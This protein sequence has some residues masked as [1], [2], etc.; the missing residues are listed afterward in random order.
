MKLKEV[1][2]KTIHFFK[3]KKIESPRL[4]A[5]LLLSHGLH[6]T[7]MDIYLKY[8]QPLSEAEVS[9]LRSLV[10]RRVEG[11]PVAYIL[12]RKDFFSTQWK[13]SPAV[14][15]PRPDTEILVEEA[16]DWSKKNVKDAFSILDLGTG[17]GCIGLSLLKNIS[18]SHL[19]TVDISV[20]ALK[21]A[22]ENAENLALLERVDFLNLDACDSLGP[23]QIEQIIGENKIDILVAN[24][25]YIRAN[26]PQL[27]PHVKKYEPHGAL[28]AEDDGL[29]FLK[30]W[31]KNYSVLLNR[32]SVVLMELDPE[33]ANSMKQH[34]E[35]LHIF[36]KIKILKDLSGLD[37][38]IAG[39]TDH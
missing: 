26:H 10:K 15:I 27:H 5:E 7:R 32:P 14:L 6:I 2:E 19:V 12:G 35:N 39:Y 4:D 29:F 13:V 18:N 16:L 11:E 31:S 36:N 21:I 22:K 33:Q 24:P 37:R 8:E 17:S 23:K 25:P 9:T 34:F 38:V 28:F 30:T 3:E 1:F 20:E